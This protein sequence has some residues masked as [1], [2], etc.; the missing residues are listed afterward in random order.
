MECFRTE[1][2][3]VVLV[4]LVNAAIA[5]WATLLPQH[6]FISLMAAVLYHHMAVLALEPLCKWSKHYSATCAADGV[7][8][9]LAYAR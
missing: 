4:A 3:V 5:A 2:H 8:S 9:I 1:I 6:A 7:A